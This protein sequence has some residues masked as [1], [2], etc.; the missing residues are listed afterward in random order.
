MIGRVLDSLGMSFF[1]L[2]VAWA[3]I[4]LPVTLAVAYRMGV[5]LW[6]GAALALI[7]VPFAAWLALLWRGGHFDSFAWP[8]ISDKIRNLTDRDD[9]QF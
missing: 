9:D 1:L 5:S 7:P 2:F 3:T 6:R 8:S 4:Y